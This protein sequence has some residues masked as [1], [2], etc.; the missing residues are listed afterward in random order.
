[1]DLYDF[2]PSMASGKLLSE[3]D[4][5]LSLDAAGAGAGAGAAFCF[6]FVLDAEAA[7]DRFVLR[8]TRFAGAVAALRSALRVRLATGGDGVAAVLLPC[9]ATTDLRVRR[10]MMKYN[11]V[12]A[13]CV[14][15]SGDWR[16]G[17]LS[18]QGRV[19]KLLDGLQ[20]PKF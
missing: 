5:S 6:F 19:T 9:S 16:C 12:F 15:C 20:R 18:K 2:S 17:W 11:M 3:S 8:P 10:G 1:M 7:P 14:C 4:S 13:M